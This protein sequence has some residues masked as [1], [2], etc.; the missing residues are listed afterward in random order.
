MK[1]SLHFFI[2]LILFSCTMANAQ[3]NPLVGT[4]FYATQ[5]SSVVM[6]ADW[7]YTAKSPTGQSYGKY[8][9]DANSV[10]YFMNSHGQAIMTFTI[11]G[12]NESQMNLQDAYGYQMIYLKQ[13]TTTTQP[14][15][16]RTHIEIPWEAP[17][18]NVALS[19]SKGQTLKK[20]DVQVGVALVEFILAKRL[21]A[22]EV[23]ELEEASIPEFNQNPTEFLRQIK[24]IAGSMRQLYTLSDAT[25]IG[26][27]RQELFSVLYFATLNMPKAQQP[28]LI[29]IMNRHIEVLTYDVTNK[30]VLTEADIQGMINYTAFQAQLS[31]QNQ[32]FTESDKAAYRQQIITLFSQFPL[33]QKQY[34]C[35][36]SLL[37]DV[38]SANWQKMTY[39][40]QQQV[41]AQYQPQVNQNSSFN[42]A[43]WNAN[44]EKWKKY[45]E[46]KY[47]VTTTNNSKNKSSSNNTCWECFKIMQNMSTESHVTTMNIIENMGDSG[48]Y[49]ETTY[50][51]W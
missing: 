50:N 36:A 44:A 17:Q 38:V 51:N 42:N 33:E 14:Q 45:Y 49:W 8:T 1:M 20:A 12:I 34:L 30:L 10:L 35:S 41:I 4:W 39:A 7:T 28:K 31:G 6:N 22:R 32:N 5:N 21:N 2:Y 24:D 37:W 18:F 48:N 29:E 23:S 27:A 9:Y 11:L 26:A 13:K 19:N 16:A 15:A 3:T 25:K 43:E 40:Q 46:E 47:P